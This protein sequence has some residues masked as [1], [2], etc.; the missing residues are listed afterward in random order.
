MKKIREGGNK[1]RG[2]GGHY[3]L[4]I[5]GHVTAPTRQARRKAERKRIKSLKKSLKLAKAEI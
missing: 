4:V 3:G 2:G 1:M 5:S